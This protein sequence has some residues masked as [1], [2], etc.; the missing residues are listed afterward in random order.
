MAKDKTLKKWWCQDTLGA[1]PPLTWRT[2]TGELAGCWR[3]L[4]LLSSFASNFWTDLAFTCSLWHLW[5]FS[6]Q[7][8][9]VALYSCAQLGP[10]TTGLPRDSGCSI[11]NWG[12]WVWDS[13]LALTTGPRVSAT[14]LCPLL[15]W[16]QSEQLKGLLTWDQEVAPRIILLWSNGHHQKKKQ[17]KTNKCWRGCGEKGTLLHSWW[18]HKLTQP[19]WRAEWRCLRKLKIELLYDQ[20][21]QWLCIHPEKCIIEKGTCPPVFMAALFTVART[22]KQPRCPSTD[23]QIKKMWERYIYTHTH[24]YTH[25]GILLSHNRKEF[26]PVLVKWMNPEPVIQSE[27]NQK[28]ENKYCISMHIYGV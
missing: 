23:E 15:S 4:P 27:V 6:P 8:W 22:R 19:L 5:A 3:I 25:N 21:I 7:A 11:A 16:H 26:E 17:K 20:A 1:P 2:L 12:V 18:E 10:Q 9:T 28:E 14:L 24:T 13:V